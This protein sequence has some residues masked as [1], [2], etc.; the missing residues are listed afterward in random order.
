MP[1]ADKPNTR[2]VRWLVF[3]DDWGRHPSSCQFLFREIA[4]REPVL[5]VNTIGMRPPHFD[6]ATVERGL[7]KCREWLLGIRQQHAGFETPELLTVFAPI[8][9]PWFRS[10]LDR[11]LNRIMLLRQLRRYL[12]DSNYFTVGVATVPVM[13]DCMEELPV[14]RWVYYCVD[15]WDHWPGIDSKAVRRL[16]EKT[17]ER[18]DCV[19]AASL[20][21]VDKMER[22]GHK[23]NFLPHGFD[24]RNWFRST[25][26]PAEQLVDLER[27]IVLHWGL[28]SDLIDTELVRELSRQMSQGTICLVGRDYTSNGT[29]RSINRVCRLPPVAPREIPRLAAAADVLVMLY[30]VTENTLA[31]QPLKLLE[32]LASG[33]PA[34]VPAIPANLAWQDALDVAVNHEDFIQK[35]LLRIQTGL[36]PEQQQAR[37]RLADY[38]WSKQAERFRQWAI[39]QMGE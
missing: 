21:L 38:T 37:C 28:I 24:E 27:P 6:W 14:D 36:P 15:D 25:L 23:A 33:K 35:V 18:V 2:P 19:I 10:T 1:H 11:R 3:S 30:R 39:G 13:A 7:E 12:L 29:L 34:V 4:K 32:Y 8:M 26:S 22:Y 9:W 17:L 16:E 31:S 5:W 20:A